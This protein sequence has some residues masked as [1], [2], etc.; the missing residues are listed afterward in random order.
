[1]KVFNGS[2][3]LELLVLHAPH[4][5]IQACNRINSETITKKH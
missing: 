4:I 5:D 2:E 3:V 1:L